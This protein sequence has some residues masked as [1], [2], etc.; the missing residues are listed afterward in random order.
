MVAIERSNKGNSVS[1]V[2]ARRGCRYT[3]AECSKQVRRRV[4]VVDDNEDAA[5]SLGG[6]LQ[7]LGADVRIARNGGAAID[8]A[9]AFHPA[10]VFL[11]LGMPG[12]DGYETARRIRALPDGGA[13]M[14]IALTGWGQE[15]DRLQT[16]AAGFNCHLVKPA[17]IGGL[18]TVLASLARQTP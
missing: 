1:T 6:V 2:D 15:R 11:D 17:D 8:A 4:L 5:D 14:L 18:Q 9:A 13:I 7:L 16:K 3:P 10:A 12:L